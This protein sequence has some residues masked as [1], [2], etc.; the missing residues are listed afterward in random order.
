[1][2]GLATGGILAAGGLFFSRKVAKW[3]RMFANLPTDRR[4]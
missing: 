3:K 2:V 1:M 4:I